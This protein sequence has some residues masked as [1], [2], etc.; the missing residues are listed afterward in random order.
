MGCNEVTHVATGDHKAAHLRRSE[1]RLHGL[2]L[3]EEAQLGA[4]RGGELGQLL[5]LAHQRL[6][7]RAQRGAV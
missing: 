3:V 7:A 4:Q 1:L 5:A 6:A 2:E